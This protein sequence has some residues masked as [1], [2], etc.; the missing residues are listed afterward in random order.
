MNQSNAAIEIAAQDYRDQKLADYLGDGGYSEPELGSY[1]H[2]VAFYG[3]YA[4]HDQLDLIEWIEQGDHI[5]PISKILFEALK[6]D[7]K[8]PAPSA[9]RDWQKLVEAM[10]AAAQDYFNEKV[11]A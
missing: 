9:A 3:E 1:V 6:D 4:S 5:A 8:N 10:S 2:D 11:A 7:P